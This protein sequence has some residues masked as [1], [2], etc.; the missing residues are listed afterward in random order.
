M[1]NLVAFTNV[2]GVDIYHLDYDCYIAH[3][4]FAHTPYAPKWDALDLTLIKDEGPT[5]KVNQMVGLNFDYLASVSE[6]ECQ[7]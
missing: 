6:S 7:K 4:D 5:Q 3:L 2:F 1:Q